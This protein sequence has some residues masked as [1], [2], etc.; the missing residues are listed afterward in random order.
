MAIC[1]RY[2]HGSNE[3]CIS[4]V[5]AKKLDASSL[6]DLIQTTLSSMGLDP[7]KAVVQCY[8]GAAAMSGVKSGVQAGMREMYEKA[9]YIH[10][11]AHKLDLVLVNACSDIPHVLDFFFN[12][13]VSS[14][15]LFWIYSVA[16]K[17]PGQRELHP[18][19]RTHKLQSLSDTR[20]NS[21]FH[22]ISAVIKSLDSLV[23]EKY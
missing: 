10:R 8:G 1:I 13:P 2:Y 21:Q 5:E 23:E 7:N 4:V 12:S 6:T 22:A 15:F 9:V 11:W 20:W 14:H 18:N 3:R 16:L 17:V 19:D